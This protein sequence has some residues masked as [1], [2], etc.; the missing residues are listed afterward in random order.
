MAD[1]DPV[2]RKHGNL[3]RAAANIHDHRALTVIPRE[4]EAHHRRDRL[5][6]EDCLPCAHSHSRF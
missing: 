6:D 1:H 3:R 5:I 4:P 2:F